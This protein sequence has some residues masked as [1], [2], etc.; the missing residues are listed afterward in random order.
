MLDGCRTEGT[1]RGGLLMGSCFGF[2]VFLERLR[3]RR[4][5]RL[6]TEDGGRVSN[7]R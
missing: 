7:R 3:Q 2:F 5:E 1:S 6:G 4:L